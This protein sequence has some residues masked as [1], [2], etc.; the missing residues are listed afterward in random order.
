MIPSQIHLYEVSC[1]LYRGGKLTT[2]SFFF[3]FRYNLTGLC[4]N[5]I[6]LFL[7][8][9]LVKHQ[10][11]DAREFLPS[12]WCCRPDLHVARLRWSSLPDPNHA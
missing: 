3:C 7:C 5:M 12:S 4:N 6:G 2:L 8:R 11:Q 1:I 10:R 9:S